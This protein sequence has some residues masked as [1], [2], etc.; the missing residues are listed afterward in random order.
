MSKTPHIFIQK[1]NGTFA[2]CYGETLVREPYWTVLATYP[3]LDQT[4]PHESWAQ[5]RR[6]VEQAERDKIVNDLDADWQA[7]YDSLGA[8]IVACF[9]FRHH[10]YNSIINL[11]SRRSIAEDICQ[12][13]SG[14]QE[15]MH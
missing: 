15:R 11:G 6:L 14:L 8:A 2:I 9:R 3:T 5:A 7:L 12:E 1:L 4:N 13:L 10:K